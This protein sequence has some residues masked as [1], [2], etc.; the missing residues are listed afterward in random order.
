MNK[1]RKDFVRRKDF[2]FEKRLCF[3]KG[4]CPV[5]DETKVEEQLENTGCEG[6]RGEERLGKLIYRKSQSGR[7]GKAP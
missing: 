7:F 4:L 2:A 1:G 3:K 6:R 5:S